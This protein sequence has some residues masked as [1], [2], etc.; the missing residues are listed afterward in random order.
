MSIVL[1][2]L[3]LG[4]IPAYLG[5][6]VFSQRFL[7]PL[8]YSSLIMDARSELQ[9]HP[10]S[11]VRLTTAV[12]PTSDNDPYPYLTLKL[13]FLW[14]AIRSAVL[15]SPAGVPELPEGSTAHGVF[16]A[17]QDAF[18]SLRYNCACLRTAYS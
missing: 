10:Q 12:V 3:T 6:E 1:A 14:T 7:G 17:I 9:N 8:S 15:M 2:K 11:R 16:S 5:V 4:C 18:V 13:F